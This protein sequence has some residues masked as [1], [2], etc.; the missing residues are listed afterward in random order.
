MAMQR[1]IQAGVRPI[2]WLQYLLELQRDW[3]RGESYNDVIGIAKEHAGSY[4]LGAIYA[5]E[6]FKAKEG[7]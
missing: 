7:K 2:T 1:M 4:G 6:M 3:A 5:T